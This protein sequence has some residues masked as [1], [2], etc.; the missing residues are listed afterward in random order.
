MLCFVVFS[1]NCIAGVILR[2]GAPD[3]E[4][5]LAVL[6]DLLILVGRHPHENTHVCVG[7]LL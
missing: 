1:S 3:F 5:G 6:A 7:D 4:L 2:D